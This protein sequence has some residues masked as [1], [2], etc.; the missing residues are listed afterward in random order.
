MPPRFLQFRWDKAK[1]LR[2]NSLKYTSFILLEGFNYYCPLMQ[3]YDVSN[4]VYELSEA[5]LVLLIFARE[6]STLSQPSKLQDETAIL[7]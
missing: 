2:E 3:L 1:F 4:K 5:Y 6:I 7:S